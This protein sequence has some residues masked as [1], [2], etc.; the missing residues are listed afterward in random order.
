MQLNF[1]YV[2][3]NNYQCDKLLLTSYLATTSPT[4]KTCL[5]WLCQELGLPVKSGSG[6]SLDTLR[7]N[8]TELSADGVLTVVGDISARC[9]DPITIIVNTKH[10]LFAGVDNIV[11]ITLTD[12]QEI[13][14][15][16]KPYRSFA[17]LIASRTV[18]TKKE[19]ERVYRQLTR[20][21]E[22]END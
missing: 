13:V 5:K 21:E 11:E 10:Q 22:K 12:L 7:H 18:S 1:D 8:L 6:R 19:Q 2:A 14:K 16:K 17:K 20:K 4:T 3:Q 15:A 9:T